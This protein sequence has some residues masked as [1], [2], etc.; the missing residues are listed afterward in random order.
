MIGSTSHTQTIDLP[1]E[2]IKGGSIKMEKVRLGKTNLMV[3]RTS[4]G[5]IPIQ[6]ITYNESTAILQTAYTSGVNYYDTARVYTTSENRIGTALGH[7]RDKIII[8]SKT[9]AQTAEPL[10]EDLEK[11][12][13]ELG[14]DYI[15][16]YQFHNPPFIPKPGGEDGLYDAALGA[17]KDGKIRHIGIT[18]HK[19]ALAKE[20]V[21]SGLF[22]TM[23]FP[24]CSISTAD[25]LELVS[26]CKQH[27]VGLIAMKALGGGLIQNAKSAFAFLR[28]YENVVPIWGIEH[29]WELEEFL[30]YEKNPPV[31]DDNMWRI[32]E[33]Y[34]N[35][36]IDNYCRGC[37]YCLPCPEGINI[38][39]AA[40][41]RL[42]LGRLVASELT[43]ADGIE[44]MRKVNNCTNC[45]HC[46]M[47]CPYELDTPTIIKE[48]LRFFE[49]FI[50]GEKT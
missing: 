27:D 8:A 15:D 34:R 5:A 21:V 24:I 11:S 12:L 2:K 49:D 25:E 36:L 42:L 23:Q 4:F 19:L 50:K 13:S 20:M 7:V 38:I 43:N 17:K 6:R 9:L 3:S 29:M 31:L 32:I 18:S 30:E 45:N 14:S 33:G 1:Y 47:H 39:I 41:M 22:E 16:I 26:L 35:E 40:R 28:Q 44:A 46:V 48:N 37:G 10:K